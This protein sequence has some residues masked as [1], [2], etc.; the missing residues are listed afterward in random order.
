MNG[1]GPLVDCLDN[2][3][4]DVAKGAAKRGEGRTSMSNGALMRLTP[5]AVLGRNLQ[6]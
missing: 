6:V 5:L 3:N 2:P 4:P 1:I